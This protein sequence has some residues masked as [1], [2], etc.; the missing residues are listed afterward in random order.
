MTP[1]DI[2]PGMRVRVV[3]KAAEYEARVIGIPYGS[4]PWVSIEDP[5]F[6]RKEVLLRCISPA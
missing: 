3:T 2:K 4:G 1:A 6:G 5:A